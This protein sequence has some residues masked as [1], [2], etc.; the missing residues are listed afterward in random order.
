[1]LK[2]RFCTIFYKTDHCGTP[3][4]KQI[5]GVAYTFFVAPM[6]PKFRIKAASSWP[7]GVENRNRGL[8]WILKH[9]KET[10]DDSGVFYFADDDN[11]YD[12]RLFEEVLLSLNALVESVLFDRSVIFIK[13]DLPARQA[14]RPLIDDL[15]CLVYL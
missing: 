6:P 10:G 13:Q 12:I 4:W 11:T 9:A 1:M 3:S 15:S 5:T 14:T 8:E 7:K 2:K